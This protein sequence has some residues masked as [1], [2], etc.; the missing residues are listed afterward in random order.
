MAIIDLIRPKW[1]HS[2]PEVR[3][4]AVREMDTDTAEHLREIAASDADTRVRIEA[5]TKISDEDFLEQVLKNGGDPDLVRAGS[6]HLNKLYRERILKSPDAPTQ[7]AVLGRLDDEKMLADIACEV[8]F[9]ETRMAAADRISN[10]ELLCK[11]AESNCG[12]KTGAAIVER[13]SDPEHLHRIA[14]QASNKKVK[15][16]AQDKMDALLGREAEPVSPENTS[17][18]QAGELCAA[19][20]AILAFQ[21]IEQIRRQVSAFRDAWTRLEME[22]TH[23]LAVRFNA[24]VI[25]AEAK[26]ERLEKVQKTTDGLAELCT[27]AETIARDFPK[28]AQ[29]RMADLEQQWKALD[30]AI[31][32]EPDRT[33]YQ[34][35][36][37]QAVR[38]IQK[39]Q[40]DLQQKES[41]R[42]EKIQTLAGFCAEAEELSQTSDWEGAENRW[43][44][45][46]I[47]WNTAFFNDPES[48]E[49][50]KRIQSSI[51]I[52]HERLKAVKEKMETDKA[53]QEKRLYELCEMVE[54]AVHAENRAGLDQMIKTVQDE[55]K[56]AAP[57][58]PEAQESLND[59]FQKA[60]KEFF[61]AQRE[62][63]EKQEWERWANL[64]Q[65]EELCGVIETLNQGNLLDG[66]PQV[67]RE[68]RKKWRDIGPVSREKSEE[69]WDRFNK[70]CESA[71]QRCLAEKTGLLTRIREL[72]EPAA[73]AESPLTVN[74]SET[75]EKVRA[76]Q[77]QWNAIGPLPVEMEKDLREEFQ[78]QCNIFFDR[79]RA[80]YRD[81]D[82]ERR[83]NLNLKT[84][85][86]QEVEGFLTA[87]HRHQ[88][89][90]RVKEIQRLWKNIGPVPKSKGD[91][92]WKRFQTACNTF[93]DELKKEEP[94]NLKKKE[95][96]CAEAE[97][98]T[99]SMSDETGLEPI[100][101][102]LMDLQ[103]QWKEIGPVPP[104]HSESVWKRFHTPCDEFFNRR[105]D[106]LKVQEGDQTRNQE[107]KQKLVAQAET[108]SGSEEWKETGEK[109]KE[110]QR[111]WKEIGPASRKSEQILW[112][113]LRE[114]C[115][116][117][118]TRRK[119]FFDNLEKNRMENLKR[120]ERLCVS[121]EA[122]A[123]LV[124]PE[125]ALKK[126]QTVEA[127][128]QLSIALDYKNE[129][130]VPGNSKATWDRAIQKVRNI[131][132]EWREI[133]PVPHEHD[134][135][136]WKRFRRAADVFFS[137]GARDSKNHADSGGQ[138]RS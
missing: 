22:E 57:L 36:F 47:R 118:F 131:Q 55:W 127:A 16:L 11:I 56:N 59:R 112:N 45:L 58:V 102:K 19:V 14:L 79:L 86:C 105:K 20:E 5:L 126:P 52:Y 62:H 138:G 40:D 23:P 26:I 114:A 73:G 116:A 89:V 84:D 13:I 34:E 10:P 80:F 113:R 72:V 98:L 82:E 8:D 53:A 46:K 60:C 133:G 43:D 21:D 48:A 69:I 123:R 94:E 4:K 77:T 85:L 32:P 33:R 96:L 95:A 71:W 3:L 42:R 106:Y 97:A 24:G 90:S 50:E 81:R 67:L 35:R 101:R 41:M 1:K 38:I 76:V 63:W 92:L 30:A 51:D 135:A 15:K 88:A 83:N 66:V 75:A 103:R 93:F 7:L 68:A 124:L 129:V 6:A 121:L 108:L 104:E 78:G 18:D 25:Q 99:A 122:L 119:D 29:T 136:L 64:N 128:E 130:V 100:G 111:Q 134:D 87:D 70:A 12:L 74:W 17:E 109:L 125:E 31:I 137:T 49:L 39:H 44:E 117:F 107:L 110:I 37:D 65:K 27:R 91:A 120:K 54:T 28:D 61:I 9:P 132:K 2:D 115:D